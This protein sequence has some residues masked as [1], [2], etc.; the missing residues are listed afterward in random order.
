MKIAISSTIAA[1]QLGVPV[2]MLSSL[3]CC[4]Q[5]QITAS[6]SESEDQDY[7]YAKGI[8]LLVQ[9]QEYRSELLN[10]PGWHLTNPF[11]S[12]PIWIEIKEHIGF[13]LDDV[14]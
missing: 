2:T 7:Y 8:E 10:I 1:Q 3:P 9:D 4:A 5:H 11:S 14:D 6:S 13:E 12:E